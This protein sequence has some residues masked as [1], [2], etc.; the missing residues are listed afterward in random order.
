MN[1][2]NG[3]STLNLLPAEKDMLDTVNGLEPVFVMLKDSDF[4]PEA[5]IVPKFKLELLKPIVGIAI[6]VP[7]R[8]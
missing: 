1:A 7:E 2:P 5:A 4:V 8:S 6:P 3:E